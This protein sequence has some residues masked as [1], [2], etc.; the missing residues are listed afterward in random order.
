MKVKEFISI[1]HDVDVYDDVCEA[2]GIC[3]C[4]PQA[5]TDEGKNHF[6]EVLDYD[7]ELDF[8]GSIYTAAVKVD[9]EDGDGWK[10]RLKKAKEFFYSAA[11]YCADEDYHGWFCDN[12]WDEFD[13]VDVLIYK[14]TT[15]WYTDEQMNADN[16]VELLFPRKLV[17]DFYISKGNSINSFVE[18]FKDDYTADDT[19]GLFAFCK[20]R[21]YTA[22]PDDL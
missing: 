8:T 7:M 5:L 12:P 22:V 16:L 2:L 6:S 11:G 15:P 4:G 10:R 17:Q 3:F 20:E 9:G 21:G 18:W 19:D 14:D 13:L 1:A